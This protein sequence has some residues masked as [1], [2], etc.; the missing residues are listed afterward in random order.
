MFSL[1]HRTYHD[2]D[3]H[4][5]IRFMKIV[6]RSRLVDVVAPS[7]GRS[8]WQVSNEVESMKQKQVDHLEGAVEE[9]IAEVIMEMG[10]KRLPHLPSQR[11]IHLMAKAAVSVYEAAV[12]CSPS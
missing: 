11:T 12:E 9:A 8:I 3:A 4:D 2:L 1:R 7:K 10:L 6:I 5:R